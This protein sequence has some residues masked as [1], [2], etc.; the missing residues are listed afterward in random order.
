[1]R[2]SPSFTLDEMVASQT[3][4]RRGLDN[5]PPPE[6]IAELRRLCVTVLQPLRDSIARPIVISSGYRS[7]AVNRA[8]GGARASDHMLGRAADLSVPG[9]SVAEVCRRIALLRLPYRQLI[10][11]FGAWAHVSIPAPG[12]TATREQ[13][14]ARRDSRGRVRYS[15]ADFLSTAP[16]GARSDPW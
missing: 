3:A 5:A 11:E 8:V 1:M 2:L 12:A 15:P 14:I 13:L 10:D 6:A 7:Q 16:A 4:A 9:M